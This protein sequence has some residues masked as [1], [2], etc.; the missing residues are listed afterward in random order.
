[1]GAGIPDR[2][3][4]V[5]SVPAKYSDYYSYD[6]VTG[7]WIWKEDYDKLIKKR[8]IAK[9]KP[10][11][12]KP[13]KPIIPTSVQQRIKEVKVPQKVVE[14]PIEKP[15]EIKKEPT[16]YEKAKSKIKHYYQY[17]ITKITNLKNKF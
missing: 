9:L 14:K 4:D 2:E 5:V 3:P 16:Y 1:M 6:K 12:A 13:I 15:K 7:K 8:A 17:V 11:R 10:I